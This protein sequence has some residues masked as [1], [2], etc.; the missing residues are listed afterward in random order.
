MHRCR[1]AQRVGAGAVTQTVVTV[2]GGQAQ[3]G[4]MAG[5][6][7][8]VVAAGKQHKKRGAEVGLNG[9]CCTPGSM[10]LWGSCL[11]PPCRCGNAEMFIVL[12]LTVWWGQMGARQ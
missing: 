1:Q 6:S 4:E 3:P 11:Y 12:G 7:T 5:A 2:A 9:A 8:H 10:V